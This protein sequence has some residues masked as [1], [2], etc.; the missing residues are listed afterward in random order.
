MMT[1]SYTPSNYAYGLSE[2]DRIL[3]ELCEYN[4]MDDPNYDCIFIKQTAQ[5]FSQSKTSQTFSKQSSNN[6]ESPSSVVPDNSSTSADVKD[7]GI[8]SIILGIIFLII[9]PIVLVQVWKNHSPTKTFY[10]NAKN[11][12]H[13]GKTYEEFHRDQ[14]YNDRRRDEQYQQDQR[15]QNQEQDNKRRRDEQYQQDQRKQRDG[16]S[17]NDNFTSKQITIQDA[18]EILEVNEQSSTDEIKQ[19]RKR[20]SLQWHPDKHRSI[21]RKQIAETQM[22]LINEAFEILKNELNMS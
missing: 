2:G 18:Y 4:K 6:I 10:K 19:S 11:Q 20:L 13:E 16:Q 12:H 7:D 17:S 14:Q 5:P 8:S 15:K 21:E 1:F 9:T 3:N 22:K